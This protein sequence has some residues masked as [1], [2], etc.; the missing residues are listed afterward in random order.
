MKATNKKTIFCGRFIFLFLLLSF[1]GYGE[2]SPEAWYNKGVSLSALGRK[3]EA[4]QAYNNRS[5]LFNAT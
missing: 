3:E 2:K 4:I 5:F 1:L